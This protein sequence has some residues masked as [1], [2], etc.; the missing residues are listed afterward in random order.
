MP[1][2]YRA[3]RVAA[4]QRFARFASAVGK[5]KIIAGADCGFASFAAI[6]EVHPSVVWVKLKALADGARLAGAASWRKAVVKTFSVAIG[7]KIRGKA[8]RRRQLER[9][10]LIPGFSRQFPE[11]IVR[12]A[13]AGCGIRGWVGAAPRHLRQLIRNQNG[14]RL[15]AGGLQRSFFMVVHAQTFLA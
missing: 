8:G 7:K 2:S 15:N 5:E 13:C 6:R 12:E 11:Q 10:G 3:R 4:A 1:P 9:M 14:R